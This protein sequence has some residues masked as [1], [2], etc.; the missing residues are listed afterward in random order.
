M[1]ISLGS[2]WLV[3][4]SND[5]FCS[6]FN[7]G[8]KNNKIGS[9]QITKLMTKRECLTKLKIYMIQFY[10]LSVSLVNLL[11]YLLHWLT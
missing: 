3:S 10:L 5:E 9:F 4:K 1:T 6:W 7:V 11:K 8:M 2:E